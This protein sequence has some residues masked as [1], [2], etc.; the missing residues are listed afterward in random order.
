MFKQPTST[1][2]RVA[3]NT[4]FL[5][6]KMGITM[7][8]S[9]YT[10]RLIL[11]SLGEIDF[12]I[13]AIVGGIIAMLG[14]LDGAMTSATQRFMSFAEGEGNKEKQKNIFNVS[15]ILHA[16]IAAI[17]S[18]VL[19]VA[20]H[21][22]FNNILNIPPERIFAARAVY[23]FMVASSLFTIMTVP[24]EAVLN[25]HE[26]ML[27]YA[28]VGIV[29]SILK[30]TVA[31]IVVYTSADKLIIYGALMTGISFL[32]M[33]IMRVY[34]HKKYD[35]CIFKPKVY[36]DK[37]L[38]KEM[39]GFAGWNFI[40]T[41]VI[42]ITN[43]GQGFV[44]NVFFGTIVNAA[45]GVA[46]QVCG[47]LGVFANTMLKALNPVIAKNEGKGARSSMLS[48][49]MTGSK[50]AFFMLML[51]FVPVMV[52][53]PYI[54]KIWLKNVP[55]YTIIFCRLLFVRYLIEQLFLTIDTSI[56]AVG[57]IRNFSICQSLLTVFILPVGYLFYTFQYPPYTLHI[58]FIITS[59][60]SLAMTIYFAHRI[61]DLPVST[62]L[63][64]VVIRCAVPF[65][66][67]LLIAALPLLFMND[68]IG[69]LGV[70]L[71]FNIVAFTITVWYYG[72]TRIERNHIVQMIKAV[73]LKVNTIRLS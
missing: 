66:I 26:N 67:T 40:R 58:I 57:N 44:M 49:A 4:G 30:L 7:F 51:F 37:K 60:I 62:F 19:L 54:F 20:G 32:V 68:G 18:A 1:S 31:I 12:G 53:T 43:Y 47:Q 17:M 56:A 15:I 63:T 73:L 29:E 3:M 59:G 13:F 52:E 41:S 46:N 16:S 14:I 34:C 70:V 2:H 25:A 42:I 50:I 38:M 11:N 24:Y 45:Q 27:Y 23:Y 28:I 64:Q 55:D 36:F 10:T 72:L 69:R 35:E 21:F 65:I 6:A 9:L 5:Y 8:I 22:F 48:A 71:L 39:T 61:C 33:I